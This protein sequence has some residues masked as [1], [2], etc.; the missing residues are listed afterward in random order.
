MRGTKHHLLEM[1]VGEASYV[2]EAQLAN[3]TVDLKG[4]FIFY[5]YF[6]FISRD[7]RSFASL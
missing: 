1:A 4:D 2:D 3:N 6:H 7:G 5:F